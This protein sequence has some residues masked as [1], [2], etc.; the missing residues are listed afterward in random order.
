MVSDHTP[1]LVLDFPFLL[2]AYLDKAQSDRDQCQH[3]WHDILLAVASFSAQD[4]MTCLKILLGAASANKLSADLKPSE[5]LDQSMVQLISASLAGQAS[6]F[7][8]CCLLFEN[9]S[10]IFVIFS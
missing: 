10:K 1:R 2:L 9:S 4:A 3:L 6:A 8:T 7:E 5:E